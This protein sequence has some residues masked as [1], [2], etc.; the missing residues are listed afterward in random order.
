MAGLWPDYWGVL[1]CFVSIWGSHSWGGAGGVCFTSC[2]VLGLG[3]F[4]KFAPGLG[5]WLVFGVWEGIGRVGD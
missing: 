5:V 4:H 1:V 2:F 3:V